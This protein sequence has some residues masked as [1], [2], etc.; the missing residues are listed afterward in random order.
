M[1]RPRA[2][3][4]R[5]ALDLPDQRVPLGV[6]LGLACMGSDVMGAWR[7]HD[8]I[9]CTLAHA[10]LEDTAHAAWHHTWL[11]LHGEVM[12]GALRMHAWLV[13]S[14]AAAHACAR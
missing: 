10:C 7:M 14:R 13:R 4:A 1:G 2:A 6:V 11:C 3:L 9:M 8:E 12:V 5:E